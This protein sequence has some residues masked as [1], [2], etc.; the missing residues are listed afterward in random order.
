MAKPSRDI[1]LN[2]RTRAGRNGPNI[3]QVAA[4]LS[5]KMQLTW[6]SSS[7]SSLGMNSGNL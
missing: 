3:L 5:A 7:T 4:L 2:G 6:M 1:S